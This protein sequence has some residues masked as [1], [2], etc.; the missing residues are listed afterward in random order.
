MTSGLSLVALAIASSYASATGAFVL[1]G[2]GDALLVLTATI[3]IQRVAPTEVLARIF[4]IVE[5]IQMGSLALGS[6]L[7]S[8]L[9]S[10]LSLGRALVVAAALISVVVLGALAVLRRG[11]HE[12]PAVDEDMA[13]FGGITGQ[14]RD[15]G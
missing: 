6:Y 7:V 13:L 9:V 3:V 8:V 2:L 14:P 15:A 10:S 1:M 12:M 5:G 4:G 11:G